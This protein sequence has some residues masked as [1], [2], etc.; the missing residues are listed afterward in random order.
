M[1]PRAARSTRCSGTLTRVTV[2]AIVLAT[3]VGAAGWG[4]PGQAVVGTPDATPGPVA[5]HVV[6]K[7]IP[8]P[9]RRKEEMRRYAIRHYGINDYRLK[10][11]H[12][13]VEHFTAINSF[14]SVFN[15]FAQDV[16]D[17]EIHE[18]PQVC[19]HYVIDRDGTIYQLVSR[20]IMCRHVVGLN[21][22]S[23]GIEHVGLSDAQV[24]GNR[25]QL[26]SSLGLTRWLQD[27]YHVHTRNVIGHAESLSSPFHHERIKSLRNA[28]HDDFKRPAM[29]EYRR[30]LSHLPPPRGK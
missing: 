29:N 17:V 8:F 10:D 22:T 4:T 28:T 2:A 7:R 9:A 12:V 14:G 6:Q 19:A 21:Y 30:K 13:I 24:M 20:A 11:P 1:A 25:R 26:R 27:R 5:P 3:L 15:T 16:P 23:I 18:L